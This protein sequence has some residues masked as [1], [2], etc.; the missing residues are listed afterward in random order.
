MH[1]RPARCTAADVAVRMAQPRNCK[2][3]APQCP[4]AETPSDG[5]HAI[6][7]GAFRDLAHAEGA[8]SRHH[9][10]RG[11]PPPACLVADGHSTYPSGGRTAE[12]IRTDVNTELAWRVAPEA[13][14]SATFPAAGG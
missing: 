13:A 8:S 11:R 6:H 7:A 9:R 1:S 10:I 3:W 2:R 14:D 5:P 12:A 4:T